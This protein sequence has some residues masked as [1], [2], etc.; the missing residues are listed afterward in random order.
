[1]AVVL[2]IAITH[3]K[4]RTRQSLVSV[5]GVATGVGF[6]IAM[7]ALMQGSQNDFVT[8]IIDSMP[9]VTIKD[10]FRE[11][12]A[13][14]ARQAF[15]DAALALSGEKP[16]EEL[17]GIKKAKE[18]VARLRARPGV[19]VAPTLRGQAV[20]RYG[21]KDEG[22]ALVGVEPEAEAR[23]SSLA[24]DMRT[25]SL[26]AL[27]TTANGLIIGDGLAKKL[28]AGHGALLTVTSA[29]GANLKMRVVGLFH[30]GVVSLDNGQAL[31]LLKKAQVLQDRPN[32]INEIRLKLDDVEQA[33]TLARAIEAQIGYRS[34]SWDEANE[35]ILEVFVIR[36]FIMYTVVGAILL[37]AGL[38]IFNIISTITYEKARDIAILKSMGFEESDIRRIFL[39]EGLAI[40]A[41][42]SLFG[43]LFGYAICQGLG[44]I[45]F[46]LE[47]LTEVTGLPL[48][49]SPLHYL[50]AA[51][52]ALLSAG[53]A[54]YLPARKAAR[55]NPV[56]IVRGAA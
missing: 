49:Y 48:A 21:G 33:R 44:S 40:G 47:G 10:E 26:D 31:T 13:Q 55:L 30:T 25:G 37:V 23:V 15:P 27:R 52:F 56:D 42:G 53:I 20:I 7:A 17:R 54:G 8:S 12:P 5:L 4:A 14:P 28:G 50:I 18:I 39:L 6:S 46:H 24:E 32:V 1:M 51:G 3:L 35:S 45:E 29:T 9:H 11:P 38:G 34:E 22:V 41:A 16:E 36:N 19:A 2:A 43:W